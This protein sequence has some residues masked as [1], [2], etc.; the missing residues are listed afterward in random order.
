MGHRTNPV[1]SRLLLTKNWENLFPSKFTMV[2]D[3]FFKYFL[4]EISL[5]Y[6]F[7]LRIKRQ[8]TK[9]LAQKQL[10]K[11][12]KLIKNKN[13]FNMNKLVK[14][15]K[16]YLIKLIYNLFLINKFLK[17][18]GN[19]LNN[20]NNISIILYFYKKLYLNYIFFILKKQNN[21]NQIFKNNKLYKD[22]I[23]SIF[24]FKK[25][26]S[27]VA[28]QKNKNLFFAYHD[29]LLNLQIQK[30]QFNYALLVRNMGNLQ[31]N[32][33]FYVSYLES[34]F[35]NYVRFSQKR[36]RL[37]LNQLLFNKN[38]NLNFYFK[39]NMLINFMG[40]NTQLTNISKEKLKTSFNDVL[41]GDD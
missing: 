27:R 38:D 6:F 29:L 34:E 31:L 18:K 9:K 25:S 24:Y 10:V 1:G 35:Y 17:I 26:R 30:L 3:F 12:K 14:N 15:S 7:N 8:I 16:I 19:Q 40:K 36:I 5:N 22:I 2:D 28:K 13:F 41:F 33:Y 32:Y 23:F 21:K 37:K 11:T 20:L 39:D 4:I